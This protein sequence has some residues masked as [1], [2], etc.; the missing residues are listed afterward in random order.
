MNVRIDRHGGHFQTEQQDAGGSFRSDTGQR[1]KPGF[2]FIEWETAKKA[3]IVVSPAPSNLSE[4]LA[5]ARRF[6]VGETAAADGVGNFGIGG[7]FH[8]LPGWKTADQRRKR[9][10]GVEIGRVLG[11]Y[12]CHELI[13]RAEIIRDRRVAVGDLQPLQHCLDGC[14]LRRCCRLLNG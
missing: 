10:I 6:A 11:E 1:S 9:A 14:N 13:N 2:R 5:N 3:Q 8:C 4:H 12:R 7:T